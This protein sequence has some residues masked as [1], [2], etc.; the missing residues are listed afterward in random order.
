MD[1]FQQPDCPPETPEQREAA[2][3]D[4]WN[5]R[6]AAERLNLKNDLVEAFYQMGYSLRGERFLRDSNQTEYEFKLG[7]R[8]IKV[9]ISLLRAGA[10][11]P[12]PT[13]PC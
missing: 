2:N 3:I 5:L 13:C 6:K 7:D 10:G 12:K 11:R 9:T 1:R 8:I 4:G